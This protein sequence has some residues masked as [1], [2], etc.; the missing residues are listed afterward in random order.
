MLLRVFHV[1]SL[2]VM[3]SHSIMNSPAWASNEDSSTIV[4]K[5][6]FYYLF[7][8]RSYLSQSP[9]QVTHTIWMKQVKN[10]GLCRTPVRIGSDAWR[11]QIGFCDCHFQGMHFKMISIYVSYEL[12]HARLRPPRTPIPH[13]GLLSF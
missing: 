6:Y 4:H 7:Q 12:I 1:F 2:V 3:L 9:A 5:Y 11:T 10:N 13:A 8:E